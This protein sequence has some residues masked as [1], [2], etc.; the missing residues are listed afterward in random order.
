MISLHL[1]AGEDKKLIHVSA[2]ADR[3]LGQ[4][5]NPA[6]MDRAQVTAPAGME[7]ST[8]GNPHLH[9]NGHILMAEESQ[10][11]STNG[12][13]VGAAASAVTGLALLGYSQRKSTVTTVPV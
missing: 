3:G 2:A 6:G 11:S 5:A 10:A 1:G 7:E 8:Y 12:W 9:D 4:Q 13:I